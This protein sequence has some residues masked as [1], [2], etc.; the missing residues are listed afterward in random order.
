M[1][2]RIILPGEVCGYEDIYLERSVGSVDMRIILPGKI[3]GVCG[4]EDYP[5]WIGLWK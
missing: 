2:M 3:F 1:A 5:T 4:Y